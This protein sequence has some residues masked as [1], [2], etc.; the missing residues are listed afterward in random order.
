MKPILELRFWLHP[1]TW[2]LKLFIAKNSSKPTGTFIFWVR[3]N[4][5]ILF[6]ELTLWELI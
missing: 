3:F 4:I 1:K 6:I 2:K 5:Q